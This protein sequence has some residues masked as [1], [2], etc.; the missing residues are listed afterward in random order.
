MTVRTEGKAQENNE[1]VSLIIRVIAD[2]A[3]S[4]KEKVT[5]ILHVN[6]QDRQVCAKTVQYNRTWE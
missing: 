3:N 5:H 2:M 1:I 6:S 4:N